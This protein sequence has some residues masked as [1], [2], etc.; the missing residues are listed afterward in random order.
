MTL[1][2]FAKIIPLFIPLVILEARDT[3]YVQKK[4]A[5]H[6]KPISKLLELIKLP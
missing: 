6:V 5:E 3:K 2:C 4:I 1:Q